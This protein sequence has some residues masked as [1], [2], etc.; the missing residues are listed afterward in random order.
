ML[1]DHD[2]MNDDPSLACVVH[3]FSPLAYTRYVGTTRCYM[4]GK[5]AKYV[6]ASLGKPF[7]HPFGS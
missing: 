1:I 2:D 6:M 7:D 4:K 5:A 3:A